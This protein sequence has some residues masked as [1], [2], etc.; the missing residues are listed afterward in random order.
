MKLSDLQPGKRMSHG[1]RDV[2]IARVLPSTAIISRIPPL[3][4]FRQ[5]VVIFDEPDHLGNLGDLIQVPID[6][7]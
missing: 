1:G 6:I 4:D 7:L 5:V 2:T 3:I